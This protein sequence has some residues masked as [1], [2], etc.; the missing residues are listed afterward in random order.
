M[1][2]TVKV[3]DKG[4]SFVTKEIASIRFVSDAD[5]KRLA[6]VTQEAIRRHINNSIRRAGSTGALAQGFAIG[7]ILG[8]WGVGDIADLNQFV[9]YWRHVNYGSEAIG[10][11][12]QH[13]LPKGR[14]INDRWVRDETGF[15]LM[16]SQ[17]L[18]PMNYI[19][20]T[21]ADINLIIRRVLNEKRV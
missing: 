2:L 17:P 7:Q 19:E 11:N 15:W 1:K 21:V 18:P 14:F 4:Q 10:A 9:P 20:K 6:E 12:W 13:W 16:P 5:T 8:G 3:T